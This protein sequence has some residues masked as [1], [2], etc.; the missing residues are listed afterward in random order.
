[1]RKS[2]LTVK[3]VIG[4]NRNYSGVKLIV[5]IITNMHLYALFN[6][7]FELCQIVTSFILN[8]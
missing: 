6:K 4:E 3:A 2:A 7:I 5:H 8:F 1:M